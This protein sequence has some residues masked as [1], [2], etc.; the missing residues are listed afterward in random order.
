MLNTFLR[1]AHVHRGFVRPLAVICVPR[2]ATSVE[3]R[4]PRSPGSSR[5]REPN[6]G[7]DGLARR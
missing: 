6:K 4:P 2:S 5:N 3:R 1:R 7:G